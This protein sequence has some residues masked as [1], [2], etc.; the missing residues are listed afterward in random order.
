MKNKNKKSDNLGDRM[1]KYE[2][3]NKS[4]LIPKLPTVIRLDGKAFHTYTK[5]FTK[6][7]DNAL[8]NLMDETAIYL[9]SKIQCA[10][11]AFV[12][13]DEISIYLSD[14]DS[15]EQQMWYDGEVEKMVSV[16]AS[17]AA[18]KFNHLAFLNNIEMLRDKDT[19][20]TSLSDESMDKLENLKLAEFD[21]RVFQL[22]NDEE[23]INAFIWRQ[24]DCIRNSIS[25]VAQSRFSFK[26]LHKKSTK[27][28]KQMLVDIND[29]WENYED[30][31][32]T[33]RLIV[34]KLYINDIEADGRDALENQIWY[35][36]YNQSVFYPSKHGRALQYAINTHGDKDWC[37]IEIKKIRSK[38]ESVACPELVLNKDFIKKLLYE[39]KE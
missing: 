37:D 10:K 1:K 9:C 27:D 39:N 25:S 5:Q 8:I 7:F 35:Q 32:K 3:V 18:A 36:P 29:P 33:G 4:N 6:P 23:L 38:W 17:M 14:R 22:P 20:L 12:Q 21:A 16:S 26:E 24:Q 30:K 11:F 13:S 28:M 34:K 2:V 15:L 19:N 31:Q